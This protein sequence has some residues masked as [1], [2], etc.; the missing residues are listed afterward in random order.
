MEQYK[1]KDSELLFWRDRR[2]AKSDVSVRPPAWN[3]QAATGQ[4]FIKFDI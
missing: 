3:K 4:I 2:I 1:G